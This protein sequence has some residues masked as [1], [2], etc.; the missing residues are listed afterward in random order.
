MK[1]DV[2]LLFDVI[3]HLGTLLAVIVF[4]WKDILKTLKSLFT[5]NFNSKEGKLIKFI[6]IGSIPV[7]LIGYLFHDIIESFFSNLLTVGL[8]LIITGTFLLLTKKSKEKKK[9]KLFDSFLIG[10]AQAFALI[11]GI[12]RSGVTISTGLFKGIDKKT[13]FKFS[14]L[15]SIPAIIGANLLELIK[16]PVTQ[17]DIL[18]LF[19]CVITSAIMGYL[20]LKFLYRMLTKGKFYYFSFYCF[21]LG[22]FVLIYSL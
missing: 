14:F 4:F 16:N 5:L 20:S 8:S 21:V 22:L 15:L 10:I 2:P 3:L 11:P 1:M 13:V 6:I 17:I 18:P 12:S 19:V 9:L 7:A